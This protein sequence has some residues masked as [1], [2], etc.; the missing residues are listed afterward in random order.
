MIISSNTTTY[1]TSLSGVMLARCVYLAKSRKPVCLAWQ[2][3]GSNP[4]QLYGHCIDLAVTTPLHSSQREGY[5]SGWSPQPE[6]P[7]G[8]ILTGPRRVIKSR[9]GSDMVLA[10]KEER[11]ICCF[12]QD[13]C[14]AAWHRA[15][16]RPGASCSLAVLPAGSPHL[17]PLNSSALVVAEHPLSFIKC[18]AAPDQTLQ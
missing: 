13:G 15:T 3:K 8:N 14:E 11:W 12:L 7:L 5:Q 16:D 1:E 17:G 2:S 4:S 10:R 9:W 6:M 18:Q